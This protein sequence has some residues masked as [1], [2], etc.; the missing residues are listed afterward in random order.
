MSVKLNTRTFFFNAKTDFL[1]FY[2]NHTIKI[3]EDKKLKDLLLHIMELDAD[4]SFSKQNTALQV[5]GVSVKGS[6]SIKDVVKVFGIDLTLEPISTFRAVKDLA[7]NEDDFIAKYSVLESFGDEEDFKAYKK[8]N[9]EYYASE[10]L[11]YNQD[12]FGD[13]MF[14]HA[15]N[16]IEKYP[17]KKVDILKA[18]DTKNG[19]FLYEK[20]CN[21]YPLNDNATKIDALKDM[22]NEKGIKEYTDELM[23]YY[24]KSEEVLC[25]KFGAQK[26]EDCALETIV[27]NIGIDK[28]KKNLKHPFG[29]F[30]VAFYAGS[31]ECEYI[32]DVNSEAKKLLEAIGADVIAFSSFDKNDGFDIA[33][34]TDIA[35]KKAANI[36]LDAFDSGAE[37]LVVDSKE[38]HFMMDQSVKR[39]E[40]EIGRDINIPIINISQ[41]VALAVG[42]TSKEQLGLDAHK[43][44]IDFL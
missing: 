1:A 40:R 15:H 18:I 37:I 27:D 26:D 23:S 4:F 7:I 12:Y 13:S 21:F 39:C 44:N 32:S 36:V 6:M 33:A 10:M 24:D 2:K 34:F 16:L 5:N 22:L 20:E 29:D 25:S 11:K 42:E 38:S 3:E 9:R 28:I 8:L 14:I 43:I 31:F 35:Y 19:I 17:E 30:K 41:I